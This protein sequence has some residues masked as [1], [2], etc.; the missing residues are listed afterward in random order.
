ML[1]PSRGKRTMVAILIHT[2]LAAALEDEITQAVR[3]RCSASGMSDAEF[4]APKARIIERGPKARSALGA[5][6]AMPG[7]LPG[8]CESTNSSRI[9]KC[10]PR[11]FCKKIRLVA[12][13]TGLL[14]AGLMKELATGPILKPYAKVIF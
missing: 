5:W 9:C 10:S 7:W 3:L 1:A 4:T 13:T 6:A 2:M 8:Y 11:Y 14:G 12:K